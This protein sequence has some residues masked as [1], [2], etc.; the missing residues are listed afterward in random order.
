MNGINIFMDFRLLDYK[1][2]EKPKEIINNHLKNAKQGDKIE[3]R[4]IITDEITT[5]TISSLIK[6]GIDYKNIDLSIPYLFMNRKN[7][8][9]Y[10]SLEKNG[11]KNVFES[12]ETI[13]KIKET[14]R[15]KKKEKGDIFYNLTKNEKIIFK[16]KICGENSEIQKRSFDGSYECL[17]CKIKKRS[18]TRMDLTINERLKK[19]NL[20]LLEKYSKQREKENILYSFK[21]IKCNSYFEDHL[22]SNTPR[23]PT[24][25]PKYTSIPEFEI[26]EFLSS[27]GDYTVLKNN[28]KTLNGKELDIYLPDEKLAIEFNGLYWHSEQNGKDRNYHLNKTK[29]C[30]EKG[31][32]LIHIFEDEWYYKKDIIKS[33]IKNKLR[34]PDERIY[35]RNCLFSEINNSS[36]EREFLEKN[37]IQGYVPS[38]KSFGLYFNKELVSI[39]TFGKSRFEEDVFE[40]YR[41]ANKLNYSIIGAASKLFKNSGLNKEKMVS[42]CDKRLFS[43]G[44]YFKLGFEKSSETQPNY[45]YLNSNYNNR[46]NRINFQKHKLK[47]KLESFDENLTEYE[48]MIN[49]GYDRIWDCGNLRFVINF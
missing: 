25:Y 43:G 16:C 48:N 26:I 27:I 19:N 33:I 5:R 20:I 37:H 15:N 24:C 32:N 17:S 13:E 12:K 39:M 34:S 41:F 4:C 21:C 2:R 29:L 10:I 36:E 40:M 1:N 35:A 38:S 23:C 44:V 31:I 28:R 11:Y 49:N 3:Y 30:E 14:K 9:E 18:R 46:Y 7:S 45:Y 6:R 42:Y 47:N 22:H 8:Q